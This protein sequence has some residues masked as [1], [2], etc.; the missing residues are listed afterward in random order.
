MRFAKSKM[1]R[2]VHAEG[3]GSSGLDT[4]QTGMPTVCGQSTGVFNKLDMTKYTKIA[5]KK[6]ISLVKNVKKMFPL[7]HPDIDSMVTYPLHNFRLNL[8]ALTSTCIN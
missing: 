1:K 3:E 6:T 5:W 2:T 8:F 7:Q 4:A